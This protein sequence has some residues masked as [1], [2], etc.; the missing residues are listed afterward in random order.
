MGI[1]KLHPI[2]TTLRVAIDYILNS[3]KT[4][5]GKLTYSYACDCSG[6]GAE[7]DFLN[8]RACGTGL[9][10]RLAWHIVQSFN[11]DEVTPEQAKQ[12]GIELADKLL[13]GRY[14]YVL[15]THTNRNNIHNH[16]I[17][18]NVD[19]IDYRTFTYQEDRNK[20]CCQKLM[21]A[22]DE[23]CKNNNLQIIENPSKSK[24]KCYYEWQ[25]DYLGKSWKS[26]LRHLI[27]EAIMQSAN[28]EEFLEN[29]KKQNVDCVYTPQNVIKI[30][31]K[32]EGQ[33]RYSRGKTLG[34]YYDEPQIKKRIAQ[35]QFFKTGIS[36]STKKASK[37]IN[38]NADVFQTSKGLLH[39]AE[40]ENMKEAS[41]L[42]NYLT[43]HQIHSEKELE[44]K[45][46][47]QF[48][49][50]MMIVSELNK[51]Q[52]RLQDLN[53]VI[54]VLR[55]YKKY[56]PVA[57]EFKQT[58]KPKKFEKD[59]SDELEKY[60]NVTKKM[61]QMFPDKKIPN[62][63]K[64]EQEKLQIQEEIN[65]KNSEYKKIVEELKKIDE[66]RTSINEFMKTVDK[67]KK[68]ELE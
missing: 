47:N 25:Q 1:S 22:N 36:Q 20:V 17:F 49:K 56:K 38:T 55:T 2:K 4:E 14:Q 51:N 54:K 61:L 46:T 34:W 59:Y 24:G 57:D 66:A 27:D 65:A 53:E 42:I 48:T 15:A 29:L 45:A 62:L 64:L 16:I 5:N 67:E 13:N 21:K 44:E 12:I 39:W 7:R 9:G 28:F 19:M 23:I 33:Q 68:Q 30:K 35:Y 3:E 26:Q 18:N 63:E 37:I 8:I 11:E 60:R 40:M 50:R 52:N 58:K 43:T 32:M 6:A 41:R 10:N 31:F